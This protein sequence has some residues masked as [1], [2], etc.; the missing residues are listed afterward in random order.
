MASEKRVRAALVVIVVVALGVRVAWCLH[1]ARTPAIGDPPAYYFYGVQ[2]AHGKGYTSYYQAFQRLAE[3]TSGADLR[4]PDHDVPSALYPPGYPALLGVLFWFVLH[5][6]LPKGYVAAAAG[7]NVA[8]SIATLLLAFAILR[9][10]FDTRVALIAAA[11]LAIYPNLVFYTGT[12]HWETT[13][14]FLVMAALWLL[15]RQP[16]SDGG[17][18]LRRLLVFSGLLGASVLIRPMSLGLVLALLV[19]SRAAGV[20]WRRVAAQC[21]IALGVVALMLMPWTVRNLVKMNAPVVVSTEVGAAMCVSRQPGAR[22]NKDY[23]HMDEYCLPSTKGVPFDE[24]EVRENNYGMARAF[25]FVVEHPLQE[26]RLWAPRVRYAYRTDHDSLDD[27]YTTSVNLRRIL[28]QVADRYYYG[29]LAF[30][31][32]GLPTCLRKPPRLLLLLT[33]VSLALTPILLFGAPR[34]KVPVTPFVTMMAAAGFVSV[35]DRLRGRPQD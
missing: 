8:L 25:D 21:G 27:A 24:W 1:A 10:L 22:G 33:T 11:L 23:S 7:L 20:P 3:L 13:F 26:I 18:P 31:A 2:I 17:V 30:A 4:V 15:I 35:A 29:V 9:S 6:P 5:S 32:L 14:I 16:W 34:Y 28:G 19:A 12:L